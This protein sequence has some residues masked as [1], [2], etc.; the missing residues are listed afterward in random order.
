MTSPGMESWTGHPRTWEN[1]C[2]EMRRTSEKV[3]DLA[4]LVGWVSMCFK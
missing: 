4:V 2:A 3:V 1:W